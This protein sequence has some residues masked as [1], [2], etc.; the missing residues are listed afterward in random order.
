M[1]STFGELVEEASR[2]KGWSDYQLSAAIGLLP[3]SRV[4][5]PTQ[6]RRLRRGERQNLSRELVERLIEVL[7]LPEDEAWHAAGLW[8]PDLDVEGYR[9]FRQQALAGTT[10]GALTH[11]SVNHQGH[12]KDVGRL[13]P[14]PVHRRLA[15]RVA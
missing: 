14:F 6:I 4:F 11:R 7:D 10:Q 5:N 12:V 9:R 1:S 3:G 13:I 2:Q 8:P 15:T